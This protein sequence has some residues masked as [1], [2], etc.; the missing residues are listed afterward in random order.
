MAGAYYALRKLET[1]VRSSDLPFEPMSEAED[2]L[3]VLW[4]L[5]L[6]VEDD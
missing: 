4:K 3:S 2:C 5:V 6:G 1:L